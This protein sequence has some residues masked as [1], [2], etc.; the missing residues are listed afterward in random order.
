MNQLALLRPL[1][2]L[3]AAYGLYVLQPGQLGA[4]RYPFILL[5]AAILVVALQ[6]IPL[7][8]GI[9][10]SLPTHAPIAEFDRLAGMGEIWRP[11]SIDPS[12][13][14]SAFFSL[15]VP[16][17]ALALYASQAPERR[18]DV[19]T[20]MLCIALASSALGLFQV[21]SGGKGALYFYPI[22]NFG[23]PIGF[24]ANQNHHAVFQAVMTLVALSRIAQL[25][26][27]A[28]ARPAQYVVPAAVALF[29]VPVI[30]SSESRAGMISFVVTIIVGLYLLGRSGVLA[31]PVRIG[32]DRQVSG[33]LL[34]VAGG[35]SLVTVFIVLIGLAGQLQPDRI[36]GLTDETYELRLV[37]LPVITDM[38]KAGMPLG[39]G[40]GTFPKA[41]FM[42]EPSGIVT[43]SYVNQA[44]NDWLQPVIE[45]GIAGLLLV[46]SIAFWV[47]RWGVRIFRERRATT[48]VA[49]LTFWSVILIMLGASLVDYPLRA[50][51]AMAVFALAVAALCYVEAPPK[52]RAKSRGSDRS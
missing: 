46:A 4:V 19:W 16:L 40:A 1:S 23:S 37:I 26:A 13:T 36:L 45:A 32:Q 9:W 30:M 33:R 14:A 5:C 20:A 43:A 41:F 3:F 50:P 34:L 12:A 38:A 31:K 52:K 51:A 44:H 7:P 48:Y 27:S 49:R 25:Q 6:L 2:I 11:V 18:K 15:A 28:F 39:F 21:L 22:S 35:L 8:Y 10:S 47:I 24:F 29:A 17:A 42:F